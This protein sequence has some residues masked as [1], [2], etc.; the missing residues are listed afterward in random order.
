M[1]IIFSVQ[2]TNAFHVRDILDVG[3]WM[4]CKVCDVIIIIA[5]IILIIMIIITTIT[6][7]LIITMMLSKGV[8]K[9]VMECYLKSKPVIE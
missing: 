1:K 5:I 6:I 8:I 4:E 9:V 2:S 3:E 7:M